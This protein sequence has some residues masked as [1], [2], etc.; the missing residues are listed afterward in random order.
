[1]GAWTGGIGLR[2]FAAIACAVAVVWLA[3]WYFI[4][5]PPT[6]I[7]IAAGLKNGG[8]AHIAEHYRDR[9]A[10]HHVKLNVRFTKG[11]FDSLGLVN[12]PKSGVAAAFL[13]SGVS[14]GTKSPALLSMGRI[15]Y[16]PYW[17]FYR[18]T[19]KLERLSQLKGKRVNIGPAVEGAL[20]PVL[21]ANGVTA[22]NATIV[23]LFGPQAVKALKAG[24]IDVFFL[25]PQDP[26]TPLM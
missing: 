13:F 14:N 18:G 17:T 16:A 15:N 11:A 22:D 6:T 26:G 4:P 10:E 1:M 3:L 12:D 19:E 24:E 21:A 23:P 20:M 5:A 8:F 25:P 7:T 2:V 9:L